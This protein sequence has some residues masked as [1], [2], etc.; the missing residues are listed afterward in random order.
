MRKSIYYPGS[1]RDETFELPVIC[2]LLKHP[3]G[4]VLF[5]TGCSPEAA[6]N[7]EARWGTLA[8][9]MVPIFEPGDAVVAQLARAGLVADDID[10]V[11]CSHLHADHCG[12]NAWFKKATVIVHAQELLAA[13]AEAAREQG[14][15]RADWDC[16]NLIDEL[17]AE[18]DVFGDGRITLIPMP[19]HTIGMTV[20]SIA[21]DRSGEFILASDAAPVRAVLDQRYAPRNS[22]D[23]EKAVAVVEEIARMEERGA[24]VVLGHDLAQWN[25]LKSG[26]EFYD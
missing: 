25:A 10:V 26:A 9:T 19:G 17:D 21:L 3:Q 8:R 2:A 1:P 5:D 7:S 14:Y 24:T 16:G 23:E 18:R 11:I 15:F 13:R 4:N 6:T 12:C 22:W 20:A